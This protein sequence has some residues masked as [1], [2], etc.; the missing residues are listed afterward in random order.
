[1]AKVCILDSP[2]WHLFAPGQFL[3]L[4]ILY[5]AGSLKAAGHEVV[6]LDCHKVTAWDEDNQKLILKPEEMIPCDVLGI[7]AT[8]ANVHWGRE[9]AQA[10]PARYKV[11]GGS[12]AT[13]I[14]RG[15]HERFKKPSYFEGFDY[16]IIEEAEQSLVDF[17][18][19]V[20]KG[21]EPRDQLIPPIPDLCWFDAAGNL[22]RNPHL[23]LPDV[24]K[25]ARPAFREWNEHSKFY[26][27]GLSA[28]G[29]DRKLDM[30]KAL[31]A[32]LFTA[33]GCPYGCKFCADARTKVRE[34]TLEQI[35]EDVRTLAELGVKAIR[36]QDDV[37]TLKDKRCRQLADI[38]HDHGMLWRGNTR[39]NLID[40]GLFKYMASKG[41]IELGFGVEH[42]DPRML[43]IMDK[44]TTPEKNT[45]GI[46]MCQ[47]AGMVAK[48][49][50]LIGFPG[51][52][53]ESIEN[54]KKWII[55]TRPSACAWSLFQPFPGSDVWNHPERYGVTLPDN[56][57][58]RFWQMG[59]EGTDDELV[60]D[61]PGFPKSKVRQA[62]IEVA[63]L[64]DREIGHRDRRR[65]E[66]GGTWGGGVHAQQPEMLMA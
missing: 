14:L 43:K 46:K 29:Y 59:L 44:G 3:H 16:M 31:T 42:A 2:S 28:N 36:V 4:G 30:N 17:C 39:V 33:R 10:W 32:S 35:I 57:F 6:V 21:V 65:V 51:E 12:H 24:T 34:E 62:R 23:G 47:D 15:P 11:L 8:T 64:I 9:M 26:G 53:E 41:C 66:M 25:L 54:M 5:L 61:L 20:D 40:P 49:F 1:L 55:E 52:N 38:F 18:D 7:S 37:L 48:A 56:A 63:A 50:L 45:L 22:H 19:A 60:L 13:N 58:D 27:G